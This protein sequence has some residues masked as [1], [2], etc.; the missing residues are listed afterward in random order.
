MCVYE[1]ENKNQKKKKPTKRASVEDFPVRLK[2]PL[3]W[4]VNKRTIKH[5][6]IIWI[7]QK[8]ALE[9]EI[10]VIGLCLCQLFY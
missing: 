10:R 7:S 5:E 9:L 4:F 8:S 6:N 1:A 3:G 2:R